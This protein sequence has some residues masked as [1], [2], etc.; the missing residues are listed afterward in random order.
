MLAHGLGNNDIAQKLYLS[1]RTVEG[2]LVN[3]YGKLRVKSRTEAVLW[4]VEHGLTRG[5]P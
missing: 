2:H 4:A 1:V 5:Q 3:I